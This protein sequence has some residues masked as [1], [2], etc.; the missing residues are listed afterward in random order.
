MD[1]T[2]DIDPEE[3]KRKQVRKGMLMIVVDG[4]I[5]P[6]PS[7]LVRAQTSYEPSL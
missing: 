3:E 6:L 4:L 5:S 7:S 2:M 1:E